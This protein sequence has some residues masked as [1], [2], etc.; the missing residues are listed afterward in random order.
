MDVQRPHIAFFGGEPLSVPALN[1]LREA[2]ILPSLLVCSPDRPAGRGM[3]LQT[4]PAKQ[5]AEHCGIPV[6]Q[7]STYQDE[8]VRMH[9]KEQSWDL[10][11]VVAYNF[12]LPKWLLD[13]PRY[14]TINVHPS[15][16]PLLRGPSPIRTAILEDVKEAIGISI[17]L[18]DEK[19]DHGPIL[20]QAPYHPKHWPMTGP[21]LDAELATLGGSVLAETVPQWLAGRLSPHTQDHDQATYTKRFEKGANELHLDPTALPNGEEA[22][23]LLHKIYAWSGIGDTFFIYQNTRVKIK[24]ASLAADGSLSID[25]VIPA[26]KKEMQFSAYLHSLTAK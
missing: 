7:P 19:M 1:E 13:L 17:M 26:G 21:S 2:D 20:A 16:L 12:I 11:I 18:L 6:Y 15:L 23:K 22:V 8:S 9:F 3:K 10:F 24:S 4:P 25:T 14:G 5:W